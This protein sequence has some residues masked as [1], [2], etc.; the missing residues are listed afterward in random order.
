VVVNAG[1]LLIDADGNPFVA[2][3]DSSATGSGTAGRVAVT[4][5]TLVIHGGLIS[6]AIWESNAGEVVVN[7]GHL[8]IDGDGNPFAGID[9]ST[10]ETGTA[11]RV[12]VTADTLV[13]RDGGQISSGTVFGP[14]NAGEVVVNAGHLT[15]ANE[16]AVETNSEESGAAGNVRI[17]ASNLTVQDGGE[18][19]SSGTGSGSAGN[20][21]LDV[22]TL[23][24]ED[25]SIRTEG[26]SNTG[27]AIV[28]TASDLIH[29]KDAEVTS[30]G[31]EPGE[32][33]SIITLTTPLIALNDSQVTSLTGSGQP[34]QGSGLAQ[35]FGDVTVI[36]SDSFVAASST[37]TLTGAEG[38]VGS[39][40]TVPEGAFLN[41]GDLLRESCAA[42]RTGTAS[43]FTA[44]GRG[45]LPSD[46]AGPLAGSYREP[47]GGTAADRAGPVFAASFGD[48]CKAASGG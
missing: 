38:E 39:Q 47:G 16:G 48:G 23:E 28:V 22:G 20:V 42:R 29:L 43:S 15:V 35:L 31:I 17:Q 11:G 37:V 25:A 33:T 30:S 26:R 2:G 9:S 27:G 7:V 46:P 45:G 10:F 24:V 44:M 34:L 18:I 19:G 40:L 12:V 6:S 14:G 13:I 1:H 36:S 32:N 4:A 3:I 8:L 21:Q 5:N 41:V